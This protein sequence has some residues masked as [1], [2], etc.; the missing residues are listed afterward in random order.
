MCLCEPGSYVG[1]IPTVSPHRTDIHSI[2]FYNPTSPDNKHEGSQ[3][4]GA[5]QIKGEIIKMDAHD[6]I[7]MRFSPG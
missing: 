4:R 6:M 3:E 7:L 2:I 1:K 5:L